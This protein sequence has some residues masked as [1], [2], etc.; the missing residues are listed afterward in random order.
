M[1]FHQPQNSLSY[2]NYNAFFYTDEIWDNHIH[3][4]LEL[5]YVINGSVNCCVNG[6]NYTLKEREYGLCLP[7]DIHSYVPGKDTQYWVLVFSEEYVR[8]FMKEI[9]GK[10]GA[11]FKF[12]CDETIN[13][14]I[15]KKLIHNKHNLS[16]YIL[17]SCLYAICDEYLKNVEL[18]KYNQM[19]LQTVSGIDDF[20]KKNHNKK[21][22]LSD[23][24]NELGYD[25]NYMS[26]YFR[27]TFNM[28]FTEFINIYRLET[29]I[30]LLE[31]SDLNI[32]N[33]AYESGFQ[34]VRSFNHFFKKSTNYSPS[35]YR[36]I[37][38]A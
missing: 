35:E 31:E 6:N 18:V 9:S 19:S 8:L 34:S 7:Y 2:Y 4:N 10:K 36:K 16:T 27:N 26:R 23:V 30:R 38:K 17:K 12:T 1:I 15:N 32:T 20:I 14:Y 5:I 3:K 11:G 28:T 21:I 33:I 13:N 24:S 25:Y 22:T 37:T 29:A